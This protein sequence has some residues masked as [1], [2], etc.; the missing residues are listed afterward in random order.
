[1]VTTGTG[2]TP[3]RVEDPT[4]PTYP[5]VPGAT[6]QQ[7]PKRQFYGT[8]ELDPIQAKK[9]FADL[10]EEVVLQFTAKPGV[11]VRIA[12]EIQA[13]TETGFDDNLQRAVK[14][15][16]KVLKFKSVEFEAGD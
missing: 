14:E 11:K 10:V 8:I 16:C 9:Q 3:P 7:P 13:E 1:V 5:P 15:N 6:P 12:I 2:S 4:K